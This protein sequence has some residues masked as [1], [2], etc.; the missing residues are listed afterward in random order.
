MWPVIHQGFLGSMKS[1]V[2]RF[3]HES[4][5]TTSAHGTGLDALSTYLK[6]ESYKW[7]PG[8]ERWEVCGEQVKE[9]SASLH[10]GIFSVDLQR[11]WKWGPQ[12]SLGAVT[13]WAS[14]AMFSA[15]STPNL[16]LLFLQYSFPGTY[17]LP[18][19]DCTVFLSLQGGCH[20]SG[21][22]L[23]CSVL[24]PGPKTVPCT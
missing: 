9:K 16:T 18:F 8:E 7:L 15:L 22:H 23:F 19:Y 11:T 6:C 2:T 12:C 21:G 14:K 24:F 13:I 1:G 3:S 5:A 17:S 10:K 20:A 4:L